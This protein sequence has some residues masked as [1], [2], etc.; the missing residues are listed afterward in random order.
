MASFEATFLENKKKPKKYHISEFTLFEA[1]IHEELGDYVKALK[2]LNDPKKLILDKLT[3]MESQ[4]RIYLKR[5]E[6]D[7]AINV[8]K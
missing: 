7:K 2:I 6:K 8:L 3:K 4:V 1:K 5:G